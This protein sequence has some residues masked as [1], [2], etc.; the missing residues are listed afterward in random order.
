M[1]LSKFIV[2]YDN[3]LDE[4]LCKNAIDMFDKDPSIVARLDSDVF[5]FNCIN[6]TEEVEVKNNTKWNPLHQQVVIAIKT[7]GESYM[8]DLDVE[9]YWPRQN[10]LEQVKLI[11]YQHK[12][13]DR[14]ERH[15]DVGDYNSA[16]RF[17]TY[18][19]FLN[20]VEGG[21]VYFNDMDVEI[22]A[23]RGRL[24]LFPSTWTYAHSYMAPKDVDKY[25][26]TTYL[27]YT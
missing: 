23:K 6:V 24:V 17:L 18:H 10:S 16:K 12:T 2:T 11:K 26:I 7:C 25:A 22:K 14:F 27:H 3:V 19:M 1:D 13:Q 21:S 5:N 4:N 8:K 9:R 20:D 15:I